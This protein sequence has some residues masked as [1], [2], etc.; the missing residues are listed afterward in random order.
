MGCKLHKHH[1]QCLL[2]YLVC[3]RYRDPT[4]LV[5]VGPWG[6][7]NFYTSLISISITKIYWCCGALWFG[8]L[9]LEV[10]VWASKIWT[11]FRFHF[12]NQNQNQIGGW[13][14]KHPLRS[15]V[16]RWF[17]LSFC[18]MPSSALHWF[19]MFF[20]NFTKCEGQNPACPSSPMI[21]ANVLHYGISFC[22][23]N[24][25]CSKYIALTT[26]TP[27]GAED[28]GLLFRFTGDTSQNGKFFKN[29]ATKQHNSS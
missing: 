23:Q 3:T 26:G 16:W 27:S 15:S 18:S 14:A 12:W 10:L 9:E 20:M 22:S 6:N 19:S 8:G 2:P 4:C 24:L 13:G 17:R 21:C 11:R 25:P 28:R 29:P 1:D 7:T 5:L